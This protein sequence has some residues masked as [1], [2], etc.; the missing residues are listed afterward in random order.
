MSELNVDAGNALN[1]KEGRDGLK[2]HMK[3]GPVNV[4]FTKKDGTERVM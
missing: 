1:T 2:S 4:V 3:M